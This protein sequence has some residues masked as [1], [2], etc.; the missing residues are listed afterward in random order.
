MRVDNESLKTTIPS[1]LYWRELKKALN[2]Q[3][4]NHSILLDSKYQLTP[5][6]DTSKVPRHPKGSLE[7]NEKDST[8]F[9]ELNKVK[10]Y[11]PI[12]DPNLTWFDLDD[13]ITELYKTEMVKK[14]NNEPYDVS[15]VDNNIFSLKKEEVEKILLEIL[16]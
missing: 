15:L 5:E 6:R 8:F 13:L 16:D 14:L 1:E 2:N 4:C 7:Y 10:N 9:S 12:D 3:P 11:S